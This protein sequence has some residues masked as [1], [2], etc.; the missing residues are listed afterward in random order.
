MNDKTNFENET[1]RESVADRIKA[2]KEVQVKMLVS[3]VM[4]HA[5]SVAYIK[6]TTGDIDEESLFIVRKF[7]DPDIMVK[8][9]ATTTLAL[10]AMVSHSIIA[11]KEDE[12]FFLD[13]LCKIIDIPRD[14]IH[15]ILDQLFMD[16]N[17]LPKRI[18]Q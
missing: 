14:K 17:Q 15:A 6:L 2:D 13:E 3:G 16:Q 11:V 7:M 10:A 8:I 18:L 4:A 12:E 9:A 1:L 5:F